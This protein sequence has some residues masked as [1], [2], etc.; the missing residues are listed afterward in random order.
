MKHPRDKIDGLSQRAQL[1]VSKQ[2]VLD[3]LIIILFAQARGLLDS[4]T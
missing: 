1:P 4:K 3:T 2:V